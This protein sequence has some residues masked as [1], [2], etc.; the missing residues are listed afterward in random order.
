MVVVGAGPVGLTIA[1]GL[2]RAGVRTVVLEADDAVC[3]SSRASGI[4]ARTFET[5]NRVAP[6]VGDA[7]AARGIPTMGSESFF[8]ERLVLRQVAAD[9]GGRYPPNSYLSQWNIEDALVRELARRPEAEVRWQSRV[10]GVDVAGDGVELDVS[11]PLGDYRVRAPWVVAADGSRSAVRSALGLRMS[12]L[13]YD[14]TFVVVDAQVG[15]VAPPPIRRVWFDPPYLPGGLLL[16]HMSPDGIW[17]LDFQLPIGADVEAALEPERVSELIGAHLEHVGHPSRE[18]RPI[19]IS[20]YRARAITL[21]S[22]RCGRVLFAGDAA[23]L[24]PIFGGFGLNSGIDDADNLQWKLA[25]VARG[26]APE[27]LL[28]TYSDERL[29]AVRANLEFVTRAAEF[30]TPTSAAS[31]RLR[32]AALTLAAEGN[33]LA[34]GLGRHRP[35]RPLVGEPLGP[36]LVHLVDGFTLLAAT[37]L[38][39]LEGAP[40]PVRVVQTPVGGVCLVRP[41]GVVA[42]RWPAPDA[43]TILSAIRSAVAA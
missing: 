31:E 32:R 12:G 23:H 20:A 3:R 9:G 40:V 41:D 37:D 17:R 21:D 19:W 36:E 29:P 26:E 16:R 1:A 8:G 2:T 15:G 24:V 27:A 34:A 39:P 33:E 28:D 25:L 14:V 7:L 43:N 38:P 22:F 13:S 11:T 5:I 4:S 10:V 35:A 42:G 6:G 30:M 18:V